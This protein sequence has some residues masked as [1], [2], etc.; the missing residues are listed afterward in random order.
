MYADKCNGRVGVKDVLRTVPVMHV[1]INDQDAF[2][3]KYISRMIGRK[4]YVVEHT[5]AH[6]LHGRCVMS[7]RPSQCQS[8]F[9]LAFKHTVHSLRTTSGTEQ[10]NIK[11]SFAYDRVGI[12][13]SA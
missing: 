12:K 10:C 2:D 4:C 1:P 11:R 7:R 6:R 5:K 8:C 3:A 9:R 13:V